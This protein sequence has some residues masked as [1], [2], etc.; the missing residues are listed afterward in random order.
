M[1]VKSVVQFLNAAFAIPRDRLSA[2]FVRSGLDAP[3][4]NF[5]LDS[6]NF[7]RERQTGRTMVWIVYAVVFT[8]LIT[9]LIILLRPPS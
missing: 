1:L 5:E 4:S 6:H 8:G 7:M 2:G 9:L 3:R